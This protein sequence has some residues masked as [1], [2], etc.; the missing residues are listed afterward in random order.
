[1][2][3]WK[4]KLHAVESRRER[5]TCRELQKVS[6]RYLSWVSKEEQEVSR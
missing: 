6:Q 4:Q 2:V 1:M 5:L 3:N